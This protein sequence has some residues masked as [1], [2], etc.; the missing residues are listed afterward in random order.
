LTA[1]LVYNVCNIAEEF[2]EFGYTLFDVPNLSFSFD[3]EG[4]LK[5]NLTLACQL[6]LLDLLLLLFLLLLR[7]LLTISG[8][9]II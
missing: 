4:L 7:G 1:L 3:N 2:V 6:W 5:I 9:S 8:Y